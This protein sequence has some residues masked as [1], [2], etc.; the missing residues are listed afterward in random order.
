MG[1]V[2]PYPVIEQRTSRGAWASKQGASKPHHPEVV[3]EHVA[4]HRERPENLAPAGRRGIEG[5]AA[6]VAVDAEDVGFGKR[7]EAIERF[8][9]GSELDQEVN[10]AV[11]TGLVPQHGAEERTGSY[12]EA[13]D[14]GVGVLEAPSHLLSGECA[15][16]HQEGS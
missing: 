3:D 13:K 8:L 9:A 15:S 5:D 16:C 6:L 10:V 11:R 2:G 4:P 1:P 14:L 12:S 7:E